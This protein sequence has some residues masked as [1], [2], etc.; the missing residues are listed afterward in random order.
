MAKIEDVCRVHDAMYVDR[1]RATKGATVRLDEDTVASPQSFEAAL[2]ASGLLLEAI[3]SV[4]DGRAENAFLAVRP[5]GHHAEP[6]HAMGFCFFNSVAIAARYAQSVFGV[7][8]IAVVDFDVHHGNGTQSAFWND[9]N[10]LFISSHQAPLYP[11]TGHITEA[12]GP[13]ALGMTLNIPLRAGHGDVEYEAIYGSLVSRVLEQHA[14]ELVLVSAGL[15]LMQGDPLAG[16]SVTTQG[17]QNIAS[18]LVSSA[19]RT[20]N[21]RII[22]ALEGG[23]DLTNLRNGTQACLNALNSTEQGLLDPSPFNPVLLGDGQRVLGS[24]RNRWAI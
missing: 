8:R 22:F 1:V 3:D 14:P 17:I 15:D 19:A 5:P 11:G 23:Y 9:P 21:G 12:G 6:T 24:W 16:M 18:A 13:D 7:R 10:V 2:R 20:A 4:F